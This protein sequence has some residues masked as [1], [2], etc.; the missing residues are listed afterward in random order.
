[1]G[2]VLEARVGILVTNG[3]FDDSGSVT[4]YH[5]HIAP[6]FPDFKDSRDEW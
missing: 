2:L 3:L 1:M 4:Y 5:S 6:G